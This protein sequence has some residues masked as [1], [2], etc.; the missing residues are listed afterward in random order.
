MVWLGLFM[1]V[2]NRRSS[3]AAVTLLIECLDG[4]KCLAN[5]SKEVSL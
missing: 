2:Y 3:E 1:N 4:S 5:R